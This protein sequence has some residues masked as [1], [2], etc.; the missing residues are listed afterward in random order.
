MAVDL[1]DSSLFRLEHSYENFRNLADKVF[2]LFVFENLMHIS[3]EE[4]K[5]RF[6]FEKGAKLKELANNIQTKTGIEVVT[7]IQKGKAYDEILKAA[8]HNEVDMIVMST[9]THPE[10][11]HTTKHTLGNTTNRVVREA[12]VPVLTFNSNVLLRKIS[13]ILLPLDLTVETRQKVTNAISIAKQFNASIAIVSVWWPSHVDDIKLSLVQQMAQV[14]SFI[15]EDHIE[16]TAEMIE[17]EG[18]KNSLSESILQYSNDVQADLIMIMTQQEGKLV[19]FFMG[20][21]A[22]TILR[23][24]SVPVMSIIPKDL[25]IHYA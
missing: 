10:D 13:K 14:K 2:L 12:K 1:N 25:G 11:D 9:H 23:L 8:E 15:E 17:T 3:S 16:C 20:S 4:E 24:A 19:Q 7:V 18:G 22:Q 21:S 6:V 5:E